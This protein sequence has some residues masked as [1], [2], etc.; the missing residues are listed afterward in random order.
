MGSVCFGFLLSCVVQ[1]LLTSY[2]YDYLGSVTYI[3]CDLGQ[4]NLS[5]PV[6]ASV[7]L[8]K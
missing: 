4:C 8:L 6:S 7:R 5:E 3:L 1:I 2:D